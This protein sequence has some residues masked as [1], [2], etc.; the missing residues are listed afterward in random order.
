MMRGLASTFDVLRT[1]V[2]VLFF[3][4]VIRAFIMQ[5]FVVEGRSMEPAFY[6]HDYLIVTKFSYRLADPKR[7]DIVVFESPT[8]KDTN[9]IKRI[10][11]LPGDLI[12]IDSTNVYVNG[13][14]LAEPYVNPDTFTETTRP[15][16]IERFLNQHEYW[17]MGDHRNHSSDSR[18]WGPLPR[19]AILGRAWVTVF[20]LRDFGVIELPTY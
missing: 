16:S 1:V 10:I 18:E 12:R 9:F 5:P 8:L 19:S 6:D 15:T 17:V 7:G 11:G 20:P 3:A 4:F 14:K 13:A 2:T